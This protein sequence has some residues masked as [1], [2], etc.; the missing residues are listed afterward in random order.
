MAEGKGRLEGKVAIVTGAGSSGPG[1]GTGKATSVLFARE[2][3]RVLLVDR[4][5]GRAE[6]TSAIIAEEGGVASVFEAD[7]T[8]SDDCRG[9]VEAA[10]E[11]Y[12]RLDVL[13]NNVAV[14]KTGTVV[15]VEE[16]DW[17]TA[18]DVNLKGMMLTSKHAIPAMIE[19]GG[20]SIVNISSVEAVRSGSFAALTPYSVSKGGVVTLTLAMAVA[21]R[22]RQHPRQLHPAGLHLHPDG[23]APPVG[24]GAEPA[25]EG[26]AARH[27]GDGVGHRSGG[28]VP[29]Q[30]RCA[31]GDGLADAGRRGPAGGVAVV[32]AAVPDGVSPGRV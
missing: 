13:M 2:G 3:A 24:G 25:C 27:G 21:A 30:R 11:R 19:T 5:A 8:S 9:M 22:A 28:A 7:V 4:D 1:Y 23:R 6:E 10:V 16:E 31:L 29:L 15:E 26:R 14:I 18:M 12:G 20:G 17:D 32:D